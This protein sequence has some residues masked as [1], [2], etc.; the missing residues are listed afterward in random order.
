MRRKME[1]NELI[2]NWMQWKT[3][4]TNSEYTQKQLGKD[5]GLGESYI[6][7]IKHGKRKNLRNETLRKLSSAFDVEIATFLDGPQ[8]KT[9]NEIISR[10]NTYKIL[11]IDDYYELKLK[12]LEI[13]V[14]Y[15]RLYNHKKNNEHAKKIASD[16]PYHIAID[17]LKRLSDYS[18][19]D[20]DK[21]L[22]QN[23]HSTS[24]ETNGIGNE[25]KKYIIDEIINKIQYEIKDI[26][27]LIQILKIANICVENENLYRKINE[28]YN[29]HI[30]IDKKHEKNNI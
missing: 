7:Q 13:V 14:N 3:E 5:S 10:A 1:I 26:R 12:M 15:Q 23:E 19:E 2:D 25:S 30:L 17:V 29:Y 20:I 8:T 16:L 11:Y 27:N 9:L 18:D 24:I 6:S 22:N 21:Y 4:L 28:L